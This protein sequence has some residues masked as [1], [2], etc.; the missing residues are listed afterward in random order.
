[1]SGPQAMPVFLFAGIRWCELSACMCYEAAKEARAGASAATKEAC[2]GA[3]AAAKEARGGASA[4]IKEAH[5]GAS[6]EKTRKLVME[7]LAAKRRLDAA[8]KALETLKKV[9][10]GSKS[11]RTSL[12]RTEALQAR[13]TGIT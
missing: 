9:R 6:A 2:G 13:Y 7:E 8:E 5:A 10:P 3:C 12:S 4:A 1:M 11:M